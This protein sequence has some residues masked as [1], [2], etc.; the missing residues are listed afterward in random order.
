MLEFQCYSTHRFDKYIIDKKLELRP[1]LYGKWLH[2]FL[3]CMRCR[4]Q[5]NDKKA[6]SEKPLSP[7]LC[8]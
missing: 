1:N 6:D 7:T 4:W 3:R 5:D 8:Q 2:E